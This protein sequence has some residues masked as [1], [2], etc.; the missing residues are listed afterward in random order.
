MPHLL[1]QLQVGRDAGP[2]VELELDHLSL[3]PLSN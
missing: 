1:S 2:V 3:I